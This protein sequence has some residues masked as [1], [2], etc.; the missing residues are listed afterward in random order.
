MPP[1][2]P[3]PVHTQLGGAFYDPVRPA[4]FPRK[5]LRWRDDRAAAEVGLEGLDDGAWLRHF[6]DFE[7]LPDNLPEPL[8]LR[9]HGHQFLSYNPD[10]GDGRGFLFAQLRDGAGRL[11]DLGTKGSG[12]T[13]WSRGGDGKLTLQGG[14]REVLAAELLAARGVSTCRILSL[15]ETHEQLIR[16]DEPSPT[17]SAVLVRLQHSHIRYGTFQRL[18]YYRDR[19]GM[20]RLVD[21][22]AR[23]YLP[24][25]AE[26]PPERR[27][28][29]L[30]RAAAVRAAETCAAW[31]AAGFVHGVLNTDNMNITGESF[32]YGP[33]RF[34]PTLDPHLVAAYFDHSGLYAFGR[35]PAAVSWNLGRLADALSSIAPSEA[36]ALALADWEQLYTR[37]AHLA[38][39]R[40]LGLRPRDPARD[41]ALAEALIAFLHRSQVGYDQLFHDWY[42]GLA[43][44]RRALACPA[45]GWYRG[46][47]FRAF[48]AALEGYELAWEG[49]LEAP[50]FSRELP[51]G[52]VDGEYRAIWA[53]IHER[54]DWRPFRDKLAAIRRSAEPGAL[55]PEA[56]GGS[57]PGP[58]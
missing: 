28:V 5:T 33:W 38:F 37:S 21:H 57:P 25:L 35:Q 54:D 13:P 40:R 30:L 27:P 4:P 23:Y 51:C 39:L 44:R 31:V 10:L 53:A 22:C 55:R 7:P 48:L 11:L 16:H 43:S 14:V 19:E 34:L 15:V 36:L 41:G 52:L 49:A 50:R 32:D 42:G 17:R 3:D 58:R 6:A 8:A 9:Y 18:A 20:R 12:P 1:Y 56:A 47:E 26:L 46:P 24:E 29:G 2:R 45:A